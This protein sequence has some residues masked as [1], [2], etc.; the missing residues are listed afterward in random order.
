MS[1]FVTILIAFVLGIASLPVA[2]YYFRDK[3]KDYVL[4]NFFG[5]EVN[6][7]RENVNSIWDKVKF[8]T[9]KNKSGVQNSFDTNGAVE[10]E[11]VED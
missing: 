10:A 4:S 3:V 5:V 8:S 2:I 11:I 7:K 1:S 9:K 6:K